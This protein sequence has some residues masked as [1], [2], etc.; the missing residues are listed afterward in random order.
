MLKLDAIGRDGLEA[1][2]GLLREGFPSRSL[3]FWQ[4]GL[5]RLSD[6]SND[7][8]AGPIG[9]MLMADG[10]PVGV[11][12]TIRRRDAR[13]NRKIVNLSGWYVREEH[14]WYAPRMLLSALSDSAVVYTDLTPSKAAA[15]MNDRLGFRT[16]GYDVHLL[17]LPVLA[18]AGRRQGRLR[19]IDDLPD[20]ALSAPMLHDLARHRTLG[21]IVTIIEA[22]GK[23]YP[24]V[25]DTFRRKGIPIARV[26]YAECNDLIVANL[27]P[28]SRHLFARG[29]PLLSLRMP[30]GS[31]L[32]RSWLWQRGL[33]YQVK[34]DWD[35]R[36]IDELYSER[37]LLKV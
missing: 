30:E 10:L 8:D 13:T 6:Y 19:S 12:L 36:K 11:L 37:V 32:P 29:I 20:G 35:E 34:G 17:P 26:I 4:D 1:A 27:G 16:I 24:L 14:R 25:F 3:A 7:T 9:S 15:A 22:G 23:F 33:R 31:T 18:I 28:L 2:A 21:C 5:K